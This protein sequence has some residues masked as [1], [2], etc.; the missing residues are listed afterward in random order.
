ME[1]FGF[2][3]DEDGYSSHDEPITQKDKEK[4]EKHKN[5]KIKQPKK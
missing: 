3:G 2:G 4:R 5:Q 1:G